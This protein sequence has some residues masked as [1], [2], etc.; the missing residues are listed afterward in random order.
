M[1]LI[2]ARHCIPGL[3]LA[4][5]ILAPPVRV[6]NAGQGASGFAYFFRR[7]ALVHAQHFKVVACAQYSIKLHL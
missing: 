4:P 3:L 1:R 7:A 2:D 6:Q 5:R